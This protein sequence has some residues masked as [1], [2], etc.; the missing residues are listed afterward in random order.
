VWNGGKGERGE[1][2]DANDVNQH[3]GGEHQPD[4]LS[5]WSG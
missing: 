5:G 2:A 3:W 1:A 4:K